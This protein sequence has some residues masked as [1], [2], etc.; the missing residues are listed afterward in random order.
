MHSGWLCGTVTVCVCVCV[1]VCVLQVCARGI[2]YLHSHALC[3]VKL[4]KISFCPLWG[5]ILL[6]CKR[7]RQRERERERERHLSDL[8]ENMRCNQLF[9]SVTIVTFKKMTDR[10]TDED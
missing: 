8:N 1:C 10:K 6:I 4:M 5:F 3:S 9:F 2:S 7:R